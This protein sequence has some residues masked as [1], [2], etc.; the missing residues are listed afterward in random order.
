MPRPS[1]FRAGVL[2]ALLLTSTALRPAVAQST[3]PAAAAGPR[4]VTPALRSWRS[5]A[6]ALGAALGDPR[7][8]ILQ[9]GSP[10]QFAAGHVPGARPVTLAD[11]SAS[12]D[13]TPLSLELPGAARLEAWARSVGLTDDSRIVVV[14]STDTLQSS[15]RVIFTLTVMGFGDRVTLLDGGFP[16]WQ[17]A[18]RPVETGEAAPLVAA[19]GPLTLR[20]DLS[21]LARM[22]DVDAA[23]ADSAEAV[24]DARLP[25]FYAGNGGGYPRPGHI[26]TAVNVP[27]TT[28]SEAGT[29]KSAEALRGLFAAAGVGPGS[30]VITYCHI[31]QQGSLLWFAA[32]EAGLAA[33]LYDGSFQEWSGSDRPVTLPSGTGR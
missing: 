2:V 22:G 11:V 24:I 32:R 3:A 20:L 30:R 21:H 9:V 31:G 4:P 25:S 6:A 5:D 18:G 1:S 29:L 13:E 17:A 26:P 10:A 28:V 7:V 27:L 15:T 8:V 14:P 19:A 16:A 23:V 12:R 33:R